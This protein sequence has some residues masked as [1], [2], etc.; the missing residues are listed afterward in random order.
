MPTLQEQDE[1]LADPHSIRCEVALPGACVDEHC[2]SAVY[3]EIR[4][5]SPISGRLGSRS[6]R[7]RGQDVRMYRVGRGVTNL[8]ILRRLGMEQDCLEQK[9]WVCCILVAFIRSTHW[10]G[11]ASEIWALFQVDLVYD[12]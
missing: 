9:D 12:S 8:C 1:D 11:R 5:H 2:S 6:R 7:G 3:H 4:N 10:R